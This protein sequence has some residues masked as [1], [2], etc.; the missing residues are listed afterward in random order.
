MRTKSLVPVDNTLL[1]T[2]EQP[3]LML[4][5]HAT[6]IH[7]YFAYDFYAAMIATASKLFTVDPEATAR[8]SG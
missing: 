1:L 4:S 7:C 8:F 2:K 3:L 6:T 5:P